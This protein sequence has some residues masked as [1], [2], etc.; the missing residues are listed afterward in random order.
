MRAFLFGA[1][2]LLLVGCGRG[3][4]QTQSFIGG[5]GVMASLDAAT[6]ENTLVTDE[7]SLQ[8]GEPVQAE[9]SQTFA[10]EM[11]IP[12]GRVYEAAAAATRALAPYACQVEGV[13]AQNPLSY[14]DGEIPCGQIQSEQWKRILNVDVPAYSGQHG[15]FQVFVNGLNVPVYLSRAARQGTYSESTLDKKAVESKTSSARFG[16]DVSVRFSPK[17]SSARLDLCVNVPGTAITA[18]AQDI[19]AKASGEV[20][21]VKISYGSSFTVTPGQAS[22]DYGRG[23]FAA[24]FGWKGQNLAP[25]ISF[26]ATTAPYLSNVTYEGLDIRINDWFLRLA[27]DILRSFRVN[28]RAVVV[29]K[30]VALV[31]KIAD[32]DI[33][34]GA[35]FT[36]IHADRLL[37]TTGDRLSHRV[38]SAL[39]RAGVPATTEDLKT[40]LKDQCRARKLSGSVQWTP[41]LEE[42]CR[43]AID[44]IEVTVVP[45][46]VDAASQKAGCFDHYANINETRDASGRK[47]WWATQCRFASRFAVK[48]P[49]R[50]ADRVQELKGLLQSHVSLDGVPAEWKKWIDD[51]GG[52]A[53]LLTLLLEELDRQG[54]SQVLPADWQSRIPAL[55]A[56]ISSQ[57]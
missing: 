32:Q 43:D 5:D 38:S 17:D 50:W 29:A 12:F 44:Q 34:T 40:L 18:P 28:L 39:R 33:E 30:A 10:F 46:A 19:S 15:D 41:R 35:W 53:Y 14:A 23:C 22:F 24:D 20:L 27:D 8:W 36:K 55:L 56:Q 42:F 37:Q 11:K 3:G 2:A 25:E 45:F 26:S 4:Y 52:D 57:L 31:N 49:S 47:K 9:D 51:R 1:L 48:M 13:E 54:V 6:D 7:G 16:R 21:G